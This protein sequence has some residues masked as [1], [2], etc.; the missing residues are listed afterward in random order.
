MEYDFTVIFYWEG[1]DYKTNYVVDK[2]PEDELEAVGIAYGAIKKWFSDKNLSVPQ[3][4]RNVTF[5]TGKAYKWGIFPLSSS[6]V[7]K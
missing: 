7:A 6:D 5:Y 2:L 4:V 1:H 3:D